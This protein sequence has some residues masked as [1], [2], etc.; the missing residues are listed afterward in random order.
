MT[1]THATEDPQ[2]PDALT[3]ILALLAQA[4]Q[5]TT[6]AT[7]RIDQAEIL[8]RQYA[9]RHAPTP[10]L[11]GPADW[12]VVD[13]SHLSERKAI[14]VWLS[15]LPNRRA[16]S[17]E[18]IRQGLRAAGL[19]NDQGSTQQQIYQLFQA[20]KIR[21]EDRGQYSALPGAGDEPASPFRRPNA[22]TLAEL[23]TLRDEKRREDEQKGEQP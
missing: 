22:P 18:E 1:Q 7:A 12:P 5:D 11:G 6:D 14:Q 8:A 9:A 21:R 10:V 13:L 2:F 15:L 16:A 3:E 19:Q 17:P 4:R 20:G 23:R